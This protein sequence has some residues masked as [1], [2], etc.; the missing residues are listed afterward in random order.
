M[1][2][3][4][5]DGGL[6]KSI[7]S[8]ENLHLCILFGKTEVILKSWFGSLMGQSSSKFDSLQFLGGESFLPRLNVCMGYIQLSPLQ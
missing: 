7:T 3:V 2:A 4:K 6:K 1:M 5:I 8:T